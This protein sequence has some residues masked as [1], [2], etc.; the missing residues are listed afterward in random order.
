MRHG[1]KMLDHGSNNFTQVS[2]SGFGSHSW[3]LNRLTSS[4]ASFA[5]CSLNTSRNRYFDIGK[6]AIKMFELMWPRIGQDIAAQRGD[7]FVSAP[8]GQGKWTKGLY[9]GMGQ[10]TRDG[11]GDSAR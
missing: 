11:M 7:V 8:E 6:F 4:V 9:P 3:P 1:V 10:P 2:L 5:S